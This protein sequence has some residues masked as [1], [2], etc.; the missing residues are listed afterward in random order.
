MRG[1]V[2]AI[3]LKHKLIIKYKGMEMSKKF[4]LTLSNKEAIALGK[5]LGSRSEDKSREAGLSDVDGDI[6]SNI[7]DLLPY[8]REEE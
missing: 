5:W 7:F 2:N 4:V 6:C 1:I 3:L 8:G